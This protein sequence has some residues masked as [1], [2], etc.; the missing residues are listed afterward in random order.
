MGR[1]S[2]K[3]RPTVLLRT[4][5]RVRKL[6]RILIVCEGEKTEPLYFKSFPANPVVYDALDIKGVGNNT[7][8]VVQKAIELRDAAEKADNPYIEV[9]AVFDKDDF[10][11]EHFKQAIELARQNRIKCAYSIE[12]FEL[13][14]LL[15]FNYIDTALPRSEYIKK[16]SL[17]MG[18]GYQKNDTG[19]YAFLSK[20][21]PIALKNAFLLYDRQVQKRL[22]DQNPVTF[23]FQLV[24][25]LMEE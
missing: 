17:L 8:F 3:T 6:R 11:I 4:P 25:R 1:K 15:H 22:E 10:P 21:M 9:W 14:Y 5:S 23:V 7:V 2:Y 13:W 18:K 12:S 19:M 24:Q 20:R 16:L